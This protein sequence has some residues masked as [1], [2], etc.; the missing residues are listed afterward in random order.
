MT[1]IAIILLVIVF[2]FIF[3]VAWTALHPE[4]EIK[5]I[6]QEEDEM[7]NVIDLE[8]ARKTFEMTNKHR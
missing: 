7:N 1:I 4:I 3:Y 8:V 2:L 5:S 6:E